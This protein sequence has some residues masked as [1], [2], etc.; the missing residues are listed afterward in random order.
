LTYRVN[1][2]IIVVG[3]IDTLDIEKGGMKMRKGGLVVLFVILTA[4]VFLVI[5]KGNEEQTG[6]AFI[7]WLVGILT[8]FGKDNVFPNPE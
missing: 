6:A 2:A 3:L 8:T 1:G 7:A 5:W 4:L